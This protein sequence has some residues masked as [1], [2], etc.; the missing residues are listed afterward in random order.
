MMLLPL[1][2]L[3]GIT[4]GKLFILHGL[5]LLTFDSRIGYH[6]K[7]NLEHAAKSAPFASVY[8]CYKA[9]PEKLII[10]KLEYKDIPLV[11]VEENEY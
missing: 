11:G 8:F 6:T 3:Q 4:R 7:E 2:T 5:E 1:P 10:E 9:L